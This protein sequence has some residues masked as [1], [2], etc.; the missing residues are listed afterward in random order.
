MTTKNKEKSLIGIVE[1]VSIDGHAADVPAKIDTGA[2]SS[3]IWASNI[4]ITRDG[5]LVFTL[6]DEGSPYYNGEVLRRTDFSVASVKSSNGEAEVRYRTHFTLRVAG[7]KIKGLFNLSNRSVNK[8]KILI[9]RRTIS[10][11]FLVDV[12]KG[13]RQMSIGPKTDN[14]S[15]ELKKNPYE[16]HRKYIMNKE[17]SI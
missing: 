13:S 12:S 14:L 3:A 10:G 7:R 1:H 2:D 17:A 6:F 5:M 16:F 11:K 4:E 9:G 15:Q 8:Y